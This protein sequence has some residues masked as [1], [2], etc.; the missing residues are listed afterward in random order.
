ML[1]STESETYAASLVTMVDGLRISSLS[2]DED[3]ASYRS[4]LVMRVASLLRK[5]PRRNRLSHLPTLSDKHRFAFNQIL[6]L[7][8]Q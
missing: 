4:D 7:Y 6:S 3:T 1:Q 2:P 8:M 5:H